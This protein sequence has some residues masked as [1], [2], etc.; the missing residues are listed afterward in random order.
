MWQYARAKGGSL[1]LD[2][3]QK[4]LAGSTGEIGNPT[5]C[6]PLGPLILLERL[7]NGCAGHSRHL[8]HGRTSFAEGCLL[9]WRG[10]MLNPGGQGGAALL[11]AHPPTRRA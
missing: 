10:C 6:K 2:T 7:V 4:A 5:H 3:P 1:S 9:A 11:R 8:S